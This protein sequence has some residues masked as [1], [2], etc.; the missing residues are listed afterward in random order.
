MFSVNHKT[1]TTDVKY[2]TTLSTRQ[3]Y[4]NI[5]IACESSS[6]KIRKMSTPNNFRH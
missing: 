6:K 3:R 1:S 4:R 5:I 2:Y